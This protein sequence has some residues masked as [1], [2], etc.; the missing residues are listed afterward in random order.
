[1]A[2]PSTPTAADQQQDQQL[3]CCTSDA[4]PLTL[5]VAR[6]ATQPID[7]DSLL[8]PTHKDAARD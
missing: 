1:M 3:G 2:A 7:R 4:I 6:R 8:L 5:V